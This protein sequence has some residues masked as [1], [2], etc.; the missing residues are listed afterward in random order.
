MGA[1]EVA[2]AV[3]GAAAE[4]VVAGLAEASAMATW[5]E[6][7]MVVAVMARVVWGLAAAAAAATAQAKAAAGAGA[8][9]VVA[10]EVVAPAVVVEVV[11]A[12]I[13]EA[14]AGV[15]AESGVVY[16]SP[17]ALSWKPSASDGERCAPHAWHVV[18]AVSPSA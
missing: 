7:L 16:H 1:G 9:P 12:A 18:A 13:C 2:V 4:K 5:A 11:A 17:H 10:V 14:A 8:A 3:V 6:G 15:E